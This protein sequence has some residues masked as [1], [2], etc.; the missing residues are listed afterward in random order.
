MAER[1]VIEK[2]GNLAGDILG[3]RLG[4]TLTK[5]ENVESVFIREALE[6]SIKDV[7]DKGEFSYEDLVERLN[8][9]DSYSDF[10]LTD[11]QRLEEKKEK[12]IERLEGVI[13]SLK[14]KGY[15]GNLIKGEDLIKRD[16]NRLDNLR[17]MS[18]EDWKKKIACAK[19]STNYESRWLLSFLLDE[20]AKERL[21]QEII[22][23]WITIH[24]E[25][26]EEDREITRSLKGDDILISLFSYE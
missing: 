12:E 19:E 9:Y 5:N 23:W 10:D 20:E 6:T 11:K 18:L 25:E 14:E 15:S 8:S 2:L 1:T 22:N 7:V 17:S 4:S 13:K 26:S 21:R 24:P 3:G 16:L